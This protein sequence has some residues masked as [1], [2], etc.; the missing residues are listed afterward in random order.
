MDISKYVFLDIETTGLN[1]KEDKLIEIALVSFNENGDRTV[2]EQ[3]VNP[4][5]PVSPF[6]TRL[7]GITDDMLRDAPVI[8]E[9]K[10]QVL[11]C[12]NQ[13][14]IVAH[15]AGFDISFLEAASILTKGHP[16]ID[17]MDLCKLIYPRLN[18]YALR[19]IAR[20]LNLELESSHRALP[21][22]LLL[23]KLFL[24][25]LDTAQNLP[26][27][28]LQGMHYFLQS[29]YSGLEV[30]LQEMLQTKVRDYDFASE[31]TLMS[32]DEANGFIPDIQKA[33]AWDIEALEKM[34]SPGGYIASRLE[35]YQERRQQISMLKAVGRAFQQQRHLLV[36]AG[37]GVGKSLAY[38]IPAIYWALAHEEKVMVATHT[39][40]LQEQ[41]LRSETEF[42]KNN[43]DI[44]FKAAVL[45][46]RNNY[47]CLRKWKLT[48]DNASSLTISEKILM[49]R[50]SLWLEKDKT[51]DRDNINLNEYE[52]EIYQQLSSSSEGC[53]GSICP[54]NRSCFY[55]KAKQ[56]A[57]AADVIIV[58]HSLLLSDLKIGDTLL[59]AYR[60]L[61]IDEA[62]HLEEEG[63]KQFTELFSLREFGKNIGQLSRR[64][65]NING[66]LLFYW[67]KHFIALHE[68]NI[69]SAQDM[70]DNIFAAEAVIRKISDITEEIKRIFI[71]NEFPETVRI[72]TQKRQEKWWQLLTIS[73]ENLMCETSRLLDSLRKL[74]NGVS[75]QK[76]SSDGL[77]P[78]HVLKTLYGKIKDDQERAVKFIAGTGGEER[79]YWIERDL[80]KV[81]LRFNIT[82]L[83]TGNIFYELLFSTKTSV[84]LTSAT[85]SVEG[86][87]NYLIEQLGLPEELIDT[88]QLYSPFYYDEQA[89]L[90]I[91]NAMPDPAR[92]G[93]EAYN[94]AVAE[95]LMQYITATGG[96][97]LVLFTSHK[98]MRYMF[99]QL[100]EPFRQI[101]LELFADGIN[102]RRHTLI[103]EMKNNRHAVIFGAN[104]FWEGIDLPGDSLKSLIIVRLPFVP[105]TLPL[106]EARLEELAKEGKNGFADYSLPQA[107]LRFRQGYGRLI[108]T[109][110]DC[111]I[112]IVLDKRLTTK[113]YGTV[114][115]NS[116][117]NKKYFAG[118]MTSLV[119]RIVLWYKR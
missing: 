69:G 46:G 81:D 117:P 80:N 90:L 56:R 11:Q 115:I 29:T 114:F 34:L 50:I 108:R 79:I 66:G 42:L 93:E 59:P 83:K 67:K 96:N 48:K 49:A 3:L 100:Y 71:N 21:D 98:Q 14:I 1:P 94:L 54:Y 73:Y 44:S 8:N 28:A 112:V 106:T 97:T 92:T 26:I 111:G 16:Y 91:D 88:L 118:D 58:N 18:S 103:N 57:N 60:Y 109:I 19:S 23:E 53:L 30:L 41:L 110:N 78:F 64:D 75:E 85:L 35:D 72:N 6:I 84:V 40:A 101:G 113:R 87:F 52:N 61:I 5:M 37:T 17:S 89:L 45:K 9:I 32:N 22:A 24:H 86:N 74:I 47:F 95:A 99:D 76:E 63:T 27:K 104:T 4:G 36:E 10:N 20:D 102:G 13:K 65:F 107:V 31:K 12:L 82:P 116:L 62:H 51:G 33:I 68:I 39:I 38:L 70:L 119:E 55:Q 7:T 25:L 2:Y 77:L 15:N 43:L 105:P